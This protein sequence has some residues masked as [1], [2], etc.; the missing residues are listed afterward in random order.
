MTS[1]KNLFHLQHVGM[2]IRLHSNCEL[3][4]NI[5]YD[6]EVGLANKVLHLMKNCLLRRGDHRISKYQRRMY[7]AREYWENQSRT[8]SSRSSKR[9][10]SLEELYEIKG[11]F[12]VPTKRSKGTPSSSSRIIYLLVSIL[13]SIWIAL[14]LR[15][16]DSM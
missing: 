2:N 16:A 4:L 15:L 1:P 13:V 11:R 9:L 12:S 14:I 3:S 5:R 6:Q 7:S 10:L 8:S